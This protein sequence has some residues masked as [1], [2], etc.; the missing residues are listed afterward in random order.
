[1]RDGLAQLWVLDPKGGMEFASGAPLFARFAHGRPGEMAA[2][3]KDAADV[4]DARA[5]RL[6]GVTREHVPTREEPLIVVMVDEIASLTA[7]ARRDDRNQINEALAH[8]ISRGRAVGVVVVAALQDPRKETIPFRNLIPNRIGLALVEAEETD[9]VLG[10]G[11]RQRGADCSR[12]SLGTPG[13]GW[14]RCDGEPEPARVRAGH[15][16]D[17][18]IAAMV[19]A[20][21]PGTPPP[22]E[23]GS[24]A[25][26]E[27]R[28]ESEG[29]AGPRLL[30]RTSRLSPVRL[31]DVLAGITSFGGAGSRAEETQK[32]R[33]WVQGPSARLGLLRR[34]LNADPPKE[35]LANRREG[36]P[37]SQGSAA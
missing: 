24:P 4:M 5:D 11:A 22:A 27:L 21:T 29:S 28:D 32:S 1:V 31:L 9:L 30:A 8:L 3:L 36:A 10:K 33:R 19:A 37:S 6:R 16:S 13:I 34:A 23:K 26:V 17:D 12:I 2:V 20:Y 18:D 7:Y 35:T 15:V 14:V 25:A